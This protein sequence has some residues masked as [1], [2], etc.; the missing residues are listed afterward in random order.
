MTNVIHTEINIQTSIHPR[1]IC[2][3]YWIGGTKEN[4]LGRVHLTGWAW[5]KSV[6]HNLSLGGNERIC[7]VSLDILVRNESLDPKWRSCQ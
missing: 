3:T 1:T 6:G 7:L 4:V 2:I 5:I